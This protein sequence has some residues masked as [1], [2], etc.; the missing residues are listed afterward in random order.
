M[1]GVGNQ[2]FQF[3]FGNEFLRTELENRK[4]EESKILIQFGSSQIYIFFIFSQ[5]LT[6]FIFSFPHVS[7]IMQCGTIL[8]QKMLTVFLFGSDFENLN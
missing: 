3:Q 2:K 6:F 8:L 1:L 4:K 7:Y 5:N